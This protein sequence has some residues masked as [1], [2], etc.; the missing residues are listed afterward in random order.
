MAYSGWKN[1]Q[2]WNIS[3]W[4]NNDEPLYRAAVEFMKKYNERNLNKNMKG[5]APYA[6][7]IRSQ[8]MTQDKTPDGVKYIS[9][10]ISYKE[11]N[12]MMLELV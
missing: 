5:K 10:R 8:G 6:A 12:K 7:F 3:L 4:I 9:T 2:T 11:L 1:Y